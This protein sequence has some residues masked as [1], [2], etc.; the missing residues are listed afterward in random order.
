[1]PATLL[2]RSHFLECRLETLQCAVTWALLVRGKLA[3]DAGP[4]VSSLSVRPYSKRVSRRSGAVPRLPSSVEQIGT[5][6]EPRGS[7][8]SPGREELAQ[9]ANEAPA[10]ATAARET[11]GKRTSLRPTVTCPADVRSIEKSTSWTLRGAVGL[12]GWPPL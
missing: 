7:P 5:L 6:A 10:T 11:S 8:W 3:G 9:A 12:R 1:L 4:A 2:D